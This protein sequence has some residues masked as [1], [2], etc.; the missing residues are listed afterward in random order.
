[1][2]TNVLV[3]HGGGPT[4]VINSSLYGVLEEAR[5]SGKVDKVY[6]AMGGSEAIFRFDAV[7]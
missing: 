3:V 5:D 7:F 1:M 2:A 4:A 6:A